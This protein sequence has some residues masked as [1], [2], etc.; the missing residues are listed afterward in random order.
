MTSRSRILIADTIVP[1]IGARRHVALQDIN[2][3]SFG[4]MERTQLQWEALLLQSGLKLKKIWLR[5][6]NAMGVLEAV[7]PQ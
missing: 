6:G 2:M 5:E 3:M 4:G 1:E 7:L